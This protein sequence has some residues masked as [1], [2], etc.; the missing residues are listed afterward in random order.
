VSEHL[1]H[2][3]DKYCPHKTVEQARTHY[4]EIT[5]REMK[6]IL[7]GSGRA[8]AFKPVEGLKEFLY[9]LKDKGIRIGL[10]TSG[11]YEKAWPEIV[12]AFKQLNMGDPRD[13]YDASIT[14][15]HAIRKGEVGTLGEL[16]PKPHPWLYAET[17]RVGLGIEFADRH[18]VLGME[19]SG[20]GVVSVRLAG[21]ACLGMAGGNIME[22][23]T[24][25]LCSAYCNDF[26]EALRVIG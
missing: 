12:A 22:S 25:S 23:G 19:D 26:A 21:F 11:L 8:D 1:K 4:F 3:I 7:D 13:F 14:A 15:G 24:R 9:T 10:V 6:A 5:H 17:A 16:E 2:C 18:H 20:A